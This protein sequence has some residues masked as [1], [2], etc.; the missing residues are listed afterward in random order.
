M[1]K[2]RECFVFHLHTVEKIYQCWLSV[3]FR[4]IN[5]KRADILRHTLNVLNMWI[6]SLC[7]LHPIL[8]SILH[9]YLSQCKFCEMAKFGKLAKVHNQQTNFNRWVKEAL[10]ILFI[11]PFKISSLVGR[12]ICTN[13]VML[14][15]LQQP[16]FHQNYCFLAYGLA[17]KNYFMNFNGNLWLLSVYF[18]FCELSFMG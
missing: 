9:C 4:Y 6:Q 8:F 15:F 18:Y 5:I 17:K 14:F 1:Y 10:T 16:I 2:Q 11:F 3:M 12:N 13:V 7:I